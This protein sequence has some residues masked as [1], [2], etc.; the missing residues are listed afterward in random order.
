MANKESE[1]GTVTR[2]FEFNDDISSKFWEVTLNDSEFTV[3]F[4]KIGTQGQSKTKDAGSPEKAKSE[5][6]KL[7]REKTGKGYKEVGV[8]APK[9]AGNGKA[10]PKTA[11]HGKGTKGAISPKQTSN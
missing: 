4:G 1:G 9:V 2:L 11:E 6:D 7:I 3:R 10:N 8:F 5:V